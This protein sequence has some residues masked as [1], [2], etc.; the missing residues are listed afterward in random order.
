MSMSNPNPAAKVGGAEFQG[1]Y[2]GERGAGGPY[3]HRSPSMMRCLLL[4]LQSTLQR[5]AS[6]AAADALL[7]DHSGCQRPA[8]M[9]G[10]ASACGAAARRLVKYLM[11]QWYGAIIRAL[12]W[13][14]GTAGR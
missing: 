5:P 6:V 13:L 3:R 9:P 10:A 7:R 14:H 8:P 4:L 12:A 11:Q 2:G 1:I